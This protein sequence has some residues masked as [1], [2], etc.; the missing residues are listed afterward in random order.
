MNHIDFNLT[1]CLLNSDS[2]TIEICCNLI[3]IRAV[4]T[5][6]L[7]A[8][9]LLYGQR[10]STTLNFAR[11]QSCAKEGINRKAAEQ[12]GIL[13]FQWMEET[14]F[15]LCMVL[16]HC[17][18]EALEPFVT[19]HHLKS[20]NFVKVQRARW[21]LL[22]HKMINLSWWL[23]RPNPQFIKY[24]VN[25]SSFHVASVAKQSLNTSIILHR[26]LPQQTFLLHA[27]KIKPLQSQQSQYKTGFTRLRGV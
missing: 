14:T 2:W 11:S 4:L 3:R 10:K 5:F 9:T 12:T 19:T 1:R 13:S 25:E 7:L 21:N 6:H 22:C 18:N 8:A 26:V 17:Q 27:M 23:I 15:V 24:L 20:R 16:S